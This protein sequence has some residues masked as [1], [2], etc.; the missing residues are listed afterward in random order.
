MYPSFLG[1][2]PYRSQAALS[3]RR[4]KVRVE[5]LDA[6]RQVRRLRP[7]HCVQARLLLPLG[8]PSAAH[9][10]RRRVG[11][12]LPRHEQR[13]GRDV[14]RQA[15]LSQRGVHGPHLEEF[16]LLNG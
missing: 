3:Y 9:R 7:P 10:E 16:L 5:P 4:P 14:V 12:V 15:L 8:Q 6:R 11:A 2:P 13:Q 1:K